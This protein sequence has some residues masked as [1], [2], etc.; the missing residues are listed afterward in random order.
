MPSSD[1]GEAPGG[2]SKAFRGLSSWT[3][4]GPHTDDFQR[5]PGRTVSGAV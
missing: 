2:P 3:V 5:G 4:E 1:W